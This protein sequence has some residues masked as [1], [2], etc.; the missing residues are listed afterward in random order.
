M[1]MMSSAADADVAYFKAE[2]LEPDVRRMIGLSKDFDRI[3]P[4]P[5]LESITCTFRA[6]IDW[7][8]D[9]NPQQAFR[10]EM[11]LLSAGMTPEVM[12]NMTVKFTRCEDP[13]PEMRP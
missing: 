4:L 3:G 5:A 11:S 7:I 12:S 13:Q 9:D 8:G 2:N 6:L 10:L 1:N